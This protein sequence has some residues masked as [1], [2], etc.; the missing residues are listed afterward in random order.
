MVNHKRANVKPWHVCIVWHSKIIHP[1]DSVL[2]ELD[3]DDGIIQNDHGQRATGG[4][5]LLQARR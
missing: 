3:D 5:V 4:V 1:C 2:I